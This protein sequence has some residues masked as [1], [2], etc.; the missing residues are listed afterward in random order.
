[1]K[2]LEQFEDHSDRVSPSD[3]DYDK[4]NKEFLDKIKSSGIEPNISAIYTDIELL[5]KDKMNSFIF[6][7]IRRY[8]RSKGYDD[9]FQSIMKT[10]VK[11]FDIKYGE[12]IAK[13]K[14]DIKTQFKDIENKKEGNFVLLPYGDEMVKVPKYIGHKYIP[15]KILPMEEL[16]TKYSRHKRLKTFA[17][18]GLQCVHCPKEGK[19]LIA[20]KDV[21]GIHIDIYTKDFDLMTVDHIKPK[22]K[23]G[24]YDIENLDPMCA[25]CN[26]KK[27]AKYEEPTDSE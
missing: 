1:L 8:L 22:S 10:S 20:A 5:K 13:F 21:G 4:I 6:Y 7:I 23:G 17:E 12:V 9:G 3:E 18:K 15:I 14:S 11:F 27:A 19:Y 16:H 25:G 2:H 26:T 24:T